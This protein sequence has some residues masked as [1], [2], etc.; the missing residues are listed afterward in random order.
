DFVELSA[1]TAGIKDIRAVIERA[2]TNRRLAQ[3]TVLFVDEVHRFNKS[4]QDAFL[5]HIESG[6][7]TIIGATTENPS[8]E[9]NNALLS[10]TR[11]VVLQALDA[12][13]LKKLI[14]K[15]AKTVGVKI[16]SPAAKLLATLSG[17][18]ARIAINTVEVAAQLA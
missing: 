6:L 12:Q 9:V 10:R 3:Q 11:V 8:F 1:V 5:P 7:I 15:A 14:Q 16:G 13:A 18:D 4:Q 2:E 17:G